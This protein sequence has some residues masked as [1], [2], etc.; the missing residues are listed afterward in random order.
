M[1]CSG[2]NLPREG[3]SWESGVNGAEL[4]VV[5]L[6]VL[7]ASRSWLYSVFHGLCSYVWNLFNIENSISLL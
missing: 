2:N 6:F 7:S 1:T 5:S 3:D 4:H